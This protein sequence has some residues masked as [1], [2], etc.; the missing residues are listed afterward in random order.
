MPKI[1]L[2]KWHYARLILAIFDALSHACRKK[3]LDK[4]ETQNFIASITNLQ[5]INDK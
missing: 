4:P 5:K 2:K 1:M 3:Y